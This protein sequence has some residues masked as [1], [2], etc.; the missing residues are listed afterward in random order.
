MAKV[1]K[2]K[3]ITITS[4]K[5]GVG[6]TTTVLLLA[7]IYKSF[8]KKVLMVDLDLYT[9]SLAFVLNADVKNSVFNIC[10]DISNNRY[11]GL[12]GGDYIFHY[13]EFIDLLSAPK[14]PRQAGK[15]DKRGLEVLLN[16]FVN[17]YDVILIDTNHIL[18]MHN[19]IAFEYSDWI[20]NLFSNDA[21][22]LKNT[23]SF[24]SICKN[25]GVKNLLLV[26]NRANDDRKRYFSD[27][28][29]KSV[30]KHN[31]DYSIPSKLYVK[32]YD[33]YVMEGSLIK[34]FT[35][36]NLKNYVEVE[37]LA[38]RLLNDDVKGEE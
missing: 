31:I 16:S 18:G 17:Y 5:G 34:Y 2:G 25:I 12:S 35:K 15:V 38:L 7:S 29:I 13:D 14:D 22:D 26:L 24:V 19:M 6:K 30:I 33:M 27:Y 4:M 21:I 9:G 32:N 20:V 3:I 11:K 23:K 37:K 10:D 8:G 36:L 28:D 1:N